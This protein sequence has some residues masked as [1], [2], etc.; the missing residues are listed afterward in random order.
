M[1]NKKIKL[2][3]IV[4]I[5][6]MS[7]SS[8]IG[9]STSE[10]SNNSTDNKSEDGS[11]ISIERN[12]QGYPDL[13]GETITIWHAMTGANSQATS[14]LG[15]Y[16]V[17]Q[18][19]E[20]KFNVNIEFVHPPVGQERD[21]F[22]IMMADTEL[23]DMIFSS[24]ID[25]FYPGGVQVAYEDGILF[26]Y[27]DYINEENTPNFYKKMNENEETKKMVSDDQG[28]IIR[29]GAKFAG[30][31]EADLSYSG[32]LIRSDY[33]KETGMDVPTTIPEWTELFKKMKENGVEYPLALAG[34]NDMGGFYTTNVFSSAFGVSAG[35]F[36]KKE[37]GKISY[38]PYE[39]A[40]KD[41]LTLLNEWFKAGYINPDFTTQKEDTVMSQTSDDKVGSVLMHLYTYGSTY[42][43]TTEKDNPGKAL[44]PAPVPVLKEG[45]KLPG[46]RPSGVY[47]GD[48]KYITA[49]AKNP[50][51]CIALLDA[52]YID[53]IDRMLAYGVEG[54]AYDMEDNNPVVRPIPSNAE[55]DVLL[56]MAPQQWH[57]KEDSDLD[58]IL[59]KKYNKG[60][61]ADALKLWREQGTE[62][63]L[64][65]FILM[66]ID[67]AEVKKSY[68]T[69][70]T[71]Y[72]KEMALKFIMGLFAN[73]F[74]CPYVWYYCS[75]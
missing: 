44:I 52:L 18:E 27:T 11:S 55:K 30:S 22:T 2:L 14:D 72:V 28:R 7:M 60:A 13:K 75:I 10:V 64:S 48:Y 3:C 19:L 63:M 66:N 21:N 31:E 49:D 46:L 24:G 23:P 9:C 58:Y 25:N 54:V 4:L 56:S 38:G 71:T 34:N 65:K 57:T 73:F 36:Y 6:A 39:D 68:E 5:M 45:D 20:K 29:L 62:N 26:D 33:L 50:E 1:K 53:E 42:Y 67:E 17:I 40:Y 43:L 8:L 32:L 12:E 59:T 51:A 69:D 61:Q 15:E 16:K 37:D 74:I 70:I 41:Y 47:L 35:G